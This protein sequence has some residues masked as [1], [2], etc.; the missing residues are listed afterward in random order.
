ML[1][2]VY[3]V[4]LT[5]LLSAC[6]NSSDST[7]EEDNHG[8]EAPVEKVTD[9][10]VDADLPEEEITDPDVDADLPEE[11]VTDPDVD[12]DPPVEEETESGLVWNQGAFNKTLWQ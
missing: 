6:G 10:D 3:L 11:E 1:K 7:P 9:P 4:L 12:A 5:L 8:S 2:Y